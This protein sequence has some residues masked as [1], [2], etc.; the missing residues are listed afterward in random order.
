MKAA[1]RFVPGLSICLILVTAGVVLAA[2]DRSVWDELQE[3][4][5]G[6]WEAQVTLDADLPTGEKKGD[7]VEAEGTLRP[8]LGKKAL[9]TVSRTGADHHRIWTFW[10]PGDKCIRWQSI[11][12]SGTIGSGTISKNA[13]GKWVVSDQSVTGDGV[14]ISGTSTI[15]I[16]D[17]GNTH[18]W[19]ATQRKR[20]GQD[21]P[22]NT[23]V[24]KR[25]KP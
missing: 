17:G 10:H 18:T 7:V 16:T 20:D 1:K 23:T 13:N 19:V 15:T 3:A 11:S 22:D 24:W 21:L 25:V 12:S 4:F 9:E 14:R 8:I 5:I 6:T 2:E